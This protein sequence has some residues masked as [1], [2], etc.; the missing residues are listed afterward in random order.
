MTTYNPEDFGYCPECDNL[1]AY[2]IE[3]LRCGE[4]VCSK[5]HAEIGCDA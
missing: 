3:C 4:E 1:G 2:W 5:C